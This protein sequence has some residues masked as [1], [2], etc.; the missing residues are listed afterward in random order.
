MVTTT[1]FH[2]H[3]LTEWLTYLESIHP[4]SIDLGLERVGLVADRLMLRNLAPAKVILVAGTNGKGST[5]RYM[6]QCLLQGGY[7]VGVYSSPHVLDYTERVR[8][9]GQLL[10]E[11]AHCEA[12]SKVERARQEIS[13]SYFEFGTL[14]G[15]ELLKGAKL[16][17][18]ILEVGLGGRLDA[19]NIVKPDVSVV[20]SVD[21]D[22]QGFLGSD[23]EKIGF[24]KAGVFRPQKPAILGSAQ[25]PQS[26]LRHANSIAAQPW[27][28]GQD[29]E[30]IHQAGS[31]TYQGRTVTYGELSE[32]Q[33]PLLNLPTALAAL[34]ALSL[35]L[36]SEQV[37]QGVREASLP[38]RWQVLQDA[39][40]LVLDVA[41]NPQAT[42][43]LAHRVVA[44]SKSK[45]HAVVAMLSDK[46][47]ASS[48]EPMLSHV[49]QWYV[50]GLDLPRGASAAQL[51]EHLSHAPHQ[52][53]PR[54]AQ[55]LNCAL[56]SAKQ[57][58]MVLV[59]GSFYT[60]AEALAAQG[61][62]TA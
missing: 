50:A 29:V 32:P 19:T 5:C 16:D 1:P 23:L 62:T 28:V 47:S 46:D 21:F 24:E 15:I 14:A 2:S 20:T 22:H 56:E 57:D 44:A 18:I 52:L 6:E 53:Y 7:Q 55:A 17:V 9:N 39:P 59:F 36:T 45:V 51:A 13:L 38:G 11:Q 49:D 8:I 43:H 31:Y 58:D 27:V 37:C 12:F 40:L 35:P 34:E 60:V 54:V 10:G 33:L 61:V 25:L 42:R 41:H 4:T 48:L 30:L 3:S 26:V